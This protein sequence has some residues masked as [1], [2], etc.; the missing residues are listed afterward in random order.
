MVDERIRGDTPTLK[1]FQARVEEAKKQI[2]KQLKKFN[3]VYH[4]ELIK[5]L[6]S[7]EVVNFYAALVAERVEEMQQEYYGESG[8]VVLA[9][10]KTQPK[11]FSEK[12][13]EH[14]RENIRNAKIGK[15]TVT[16]NLV[17]DEFMGVGNDDPTASEP[18]VPWLHYFVYGSLDNDL[19]FVPYDIYQQIHGHSSVNKLGRFGNGELW[20]INDKE[21]FNRLL[22]HKGIS[23]SYETLKHPQGDSPPKR[24]WF[25]AIWEEHPFELIVGEPA[26][27]AARAKVDFEIKL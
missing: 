4:E 7:D 15:N 17:T 23:A 24:D 25:D 6:H 1:R 18:G 14:V 20:K 10:D 12:V 26:L 5:Y 3:Q 2:N 27:S 21:A 16:I 9:E 22:E 19:I 8:S 13:Q 11:Y